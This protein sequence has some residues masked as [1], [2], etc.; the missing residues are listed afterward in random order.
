MLQ[1]LASRLIRHLILRLRILLGLAALWILLLITAAGQKANT[2]F[3]LAVGGIGI[4]QN[5]YVAGAP[6]NIEN[7]GIPLEYVTVFGDASVM[8]TLFQ[9]EEQYEGVGR[10]MLGEFYHGNLREKERIRWETL[11]RT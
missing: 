7:F 6:R 1:N 4:L 11:E 9:V 10:S 2:W 8:E 5:V 3:L